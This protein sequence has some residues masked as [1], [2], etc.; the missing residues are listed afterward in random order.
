MRS[1]ELRL[2]LLL[3]LTVLG[4]CLLL[5]N[6]SF[7]QQRLPVLI[8]YANDTLVAISKEQFDVVLFS[9]SYLRMTENTLE[10]TSKELLRSDSI[11]TYLEKVMSLE[12][13]KMDEKEIV[14]H[15][16]EYII[17][18]QKK[19]VKREKLKKTFTYLGLGLLAG[20][21]AG[22]ITYLLIR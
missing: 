15:N 11:N 2:S 3:R 13:L 16:L 20:A 18:Q 9:F 10:I 12:R 5:V 19:A 1:L 8:P 17:K 22:I 21:E 6:D 4:L 14:I 7:S